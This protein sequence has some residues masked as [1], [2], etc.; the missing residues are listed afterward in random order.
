MKVV[1]DLLGGG[2]PSP[3]ELP[4]NGDEDVDSVTTR[5]KG[6]LTKIMDYDD[7]DHGVFHTFAGVA[8][9]MENF[10]GILEEEQGI[11]GNYLPDDADYGVKL[12]HITPCFPSTIIRAEYAQA[13]AEGT[14]N[15]DTGATASAAG[16]T[17]TQ[18]LGATADSAIGGWIYML[19]GAAAGELHYITNNTTSAATTSA[20][21][22]AVV[23]TDDF[24]FISPANCRTL[25]FDATY[26]GI[27]SETQDDLRTDAVVGIMHYIEAPGIPFQ[28]LDRDKHDGLVIANARFYHDFTIPSKNAWVAGIATS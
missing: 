21:T 8:T 25:D 16:T 10:S 19:N 6:S 13:D 22:N 28:R 20:F 1:R 2:K 17:F 23:A 11:T 4:Y 3:I 12:R 7:I 15:Y 9:A 26:T 27:K 24:L 14:D 18:D 5:Y